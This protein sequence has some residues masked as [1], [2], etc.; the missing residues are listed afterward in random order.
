MKFVLDF[1]AG[2]YYLCCPERTYQIYIM[3]TPT[4]SYFSSRATVRNFKPEAPSRELLR[5]IAQQAMRAPT[6]GNMQLYSAVVTTDPERL[7]ILRGAHFNQPASMAPVLITICADVRRFERWCELSNAAPAFRNLQG[8]M[9]AILDASLFAQQFTVIAEMQGLGTCWLGT[10]TY[11]APEIAEALN[12]PKGVVPIGTLAI[13]YPQ[14]RPAQCERLP[15][16]ALWHEEEYP[17]HSDEEILTLF[18][19]KDEFAPNRKFVEENGKQT[20]AQ[21]F[22]DVRYPRSTSDPFSAKFADFLR[23]QGFEL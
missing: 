13:G 8:L 18:K 10:T 4:S 3:T 19:A 23:A 16:D 11:N 2:F 6:T 12:L 15:L 20:L 21:V 5:E 9:A 1:L 22:T 7:T 14:E 17:E